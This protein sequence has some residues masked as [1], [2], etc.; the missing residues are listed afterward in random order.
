MVAQAS[1]TWEAVLGSSRSATY[2][3]VGGAGFDESAAS[4]VAWEAVLGSSRS[5]TYA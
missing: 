4:P 1:M 2:G 3:M 5:V